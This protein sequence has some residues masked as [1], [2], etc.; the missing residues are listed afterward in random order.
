MPNS[1]NPG[2]L[3]DFVILGFQ[4]CGSTLAHKVLSKHP[5]VFMGRHSE[6]AGDAEI[7]FFDKEENWAK[8]IQWYQKLF[9][10]K[11]NQ[12]CGEKTPNYIMQRKCIERL[13]SV[14]P[15]AKIVLCLRN[16]IDRLFSHYNHSKNNFETGKPSWGWDHTKKFNTQIMQ[17]KDLEKIPGVIDSLFANQIAELLTFYKKEQIHFM[18]LEDVEIAPSVEFRRLFEFLNI[19][20][21]FAGKISY[22][23]VHA[24]SYSEEMTLGVKKKLFNFFKPHNERLFEIVGRAVREW[25]HQPELKYHLLDEEPSYSGKEKAMGALYSQDFEL[26]SKYIETQIKGEQV[27]KIPEKLDGELWGITTFFNPAGYSNKYQHFKKFADSARQQGLKICTVELTFGDK[28]YEVEDHDTDMLIQVNGSEHNMLWQKEAMMNIAL[29]KLPESCDKIAWLDCDVIFENPNWVKATSKLLNDYK[30]VQPFSHAFRLPENVFT[31]DDLT[32]A[33]L[34]KGDGSLSLG[35][36][37][38]VAQSGERALGFNSFTEGEVG[39]AWAARRSVFA[40]I[41]F[42]DRLCTGANDLLMSYGFFGK[43]INYD[44]KNLNSATIN[45][46]EKY[47]TQLE[48]IVGKSVYY[49]N[50]LLL[51]LWHGSQ[52]NRRYHKRDFILSQEEYHPGKDVKKGSNGLLQWSSNKPRLHTKISNYMLGRGEESGSTVL[53]INSYVVYGQLGMNARLFT[54]LMCSNPEVDCNWDPFNKKSWNKKSHGKWNINGLNAIQSRD[55]L[56]SAINGVVSCNDGLLH[57]AGESIL[58]EDIEI[59]LLASQELKSIFITSA[60]PI[61]QLLNHL[62]TYLGGQNLKLNLES[63]KKIGAE[64]VQAAYFKIL[65]E[66]E[67]AKTQAQKSPNSILIIELENW[68]SK[69]NANPSSLQKKLLDVY[70]FLGFQTVEFNAFSDKLSRI[71]ERIQVH[72]HHE[73]YSNNLI[74]RQVRELLEKSKRIAA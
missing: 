3:P 20:P 47:R 4:K 62:S 63:I 1:T 27:T 10:P 64:E 31:L 74:Y 26:H 18:F 56:N 72:N 45:Y 24:R 8:G 25:R 29:E 59:A 66:K 2:N 41:L 21:T 22:T 68:L 53:N 9:K 71:L 52:R 49:A 43:S 57:L 19:D 30:V 17:S 37:F 5:Q 38:S 51:H 12:I 55:E 28:S 33:S 40:D 14:L 34:A 58:P 67:H 6:E 42:A 48:Q 23:K 61:N 15:D 35:S 69:E 54:R 39:F 65:R 16:P 13:H 60:D 7:H 50:G 70:T 46:C 32:Q 73:D 36:A 44:S 11:P